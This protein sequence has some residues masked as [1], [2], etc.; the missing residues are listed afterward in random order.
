MAQHES[1]VFIKQW[2][3]LRETQ[4]S[5]KEV[6]SAFNLCCTHHNKNTVSSSETSALEKLYH[7]LLLDSRPSQIQPTL[8]LLSQKSNEKVETFILLGN[9][10]IKI[11][12]NLT[13][14]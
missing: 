6:I 14:L 4:I 1:I 13:T 12:V 7:K 3:R 9:T 8:D 2:A 10:G 11:P 5:V